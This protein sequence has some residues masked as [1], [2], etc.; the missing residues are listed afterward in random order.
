V[1]LA[2]NDNQPIR[3]ASKNGQTDVVKLLLSNIRVNPAA[4]D[5]Y[6]IREASKNGHTEV[7][8]LLLSD[9]RVNPAAKAHYAIRTAAEQGHPKTLGMLLQDPRVNLTDAQS[10]Q[11]IRGAVVKG[12]VD[13]FALL[14]FLFFSVNATIVLD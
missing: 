6:A 12:F 13:C 5:D 7:V 9:A 3:E 2:T 10:L 8:K 1:N 11:R 4:D 14:F